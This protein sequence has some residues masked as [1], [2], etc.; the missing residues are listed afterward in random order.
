MYRID[1]RFR[2]GS[3]QELYQSPNFFA[4]AVA[5]PRNEDDACVVFSTQEKFAM[6]AGEM[7]RVE[8]IESAIERRGKAKLIVI[9]NAGTAN[10][11][12]REHID[13]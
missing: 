6:E 7:A 1:E 4:D 10:V 5:L 9:V 13:P 8:R 3:F 11:E 2:V 12:N